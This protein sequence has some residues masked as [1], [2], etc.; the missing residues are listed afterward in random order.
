MGN[1]RRGPAVHAAKC[2]LS[3]GGYL[4][5]LWQHEREQT[6]SKIRLWDADFRQRFP[7]VS[8]AGPD[9]E[10]DTGTDTVTESFHWLVL[11]RTMK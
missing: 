9:G 10:T 6:Q 8:R 3:Y 1:E 5:N 4:V 11:Q 7:L 2:S